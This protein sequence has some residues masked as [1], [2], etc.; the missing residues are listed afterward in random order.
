MTDNT[1]NLTDA[2]L[3]QLFVRQRDSDAFKEVF[4]RHYRLVWSACRRRLCG[5]EHLADDAVQAVFLVL[6]HHA[7]RIRDGCA[8]SAW[9]Y[10][11]AGFVSAKI[12]RAEASRREREKKAAN[13]NDIISDPVSQADWSEVRGHLDEAIDKLPGKQRDAVVMRYIAGKS[14]AQI[15]AETGV[16]HETLRKRVDAG[17]G[18][19]RSMLSAQN[20]AVSVA[21][22][23]TMIAGNSLEAAPAVLEQTLF[24]A[25]AHN[26]SAGGSAAS[27]MVNIV[28]KEIGKMMFMAKLKVA[29]GIVALAA[30]VAGTG[31]AILV[32]QSGETET[33]VA[34]PAPAA[35]APAAPSDATVVEITDKVVVKDTTRLGINMEKDTYYGGHH[36]MKKRIQENFEGTS[37]RQCQWGPVQDE[38]GTF[39]WWGMSDEWKKILIGGKYT[40]LSGPAKGATGTIKDIVNKKIRT[41]NGEQDLVYIMFDKKVPAGPPDTGVLLENLSINQGKMGPQSPTSD[42]WNSNQN[43]ISINDVPP[44]SFGCAAL[45]MKGAAAPSRYQF[46]TMD[47]KYAQTNGTWHI[48]LWA[49]AKAGDPKLRI[50]PVGCDKPPEVTPAKEW[51]KHELTVIVDKIADRAEGGTTMNI[52]FNVTGGDMLLDDVE[53]WMEGDKN[54]TAFRDDA[55]AALK[56]YNPGVIR[57]LQMGGNTVDNILAPKL[58]SYR[59]RSSNETISRGFNLPE[60]YELCEYLGAEPW[61]SLPGTMQPEEMRN[62]MEYLGGPADSKYG[63]LRTDLGHP[64]PWTETLRQIHVEFGNEAWNG[65]SD[66]R[67]GGFNGPDYWKGLIDEAKKSKYYT[68]N[69]IFHAG[70]WA[71]SPDRNARIMKDAPN[72]DCLAVAPYVIGEIDPSL[73]T[74]DKLFPWAW[75]YSIRRA[76]EPFGSMV[77]N[78]Q[79]AQKAEMELSIYEVNYHITLGNGPLEPRNRII[80]SVGGAVGL[81]N[82]LLQMMRDQKVRKQC[83][84][85]F[86]QQGYRATVGTVKLWG[87]VLNYRKDKERYRPTFLGC[88]IANKVIAGDMVETIQ[89]GV[90]PKFSATGAYQDTNRKVVTYDNVSTIWSYA[91]SKG[92]RRGLILFNLDVSQPQPVIVR[93]AGQPITT[94]RL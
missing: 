60:L 17:I 53:I 25:I 82:N 6:F 78:Y 5:R 81:L 93:F 90:N 23:G 12:A 68:K 41:S 32:A 36:L 7:G 94:T 79:N 3:L 80:A 51:K 92:N 87:I 4:H 21:G 37:Y 34:T 57:S 39:S 11:T 28:V 74:N 54:P 31:G 65:D 2:G 38:D 9:L 26:I 83:V 47:Q 16:G 75:T 86:V 46:S 71:S 52:V 85:Q 27:G 44:G 1:Q 77:K 22:L 55:V 35:I 13:M 18:K 40:I 58:R 50:S 91:F 63:K 73:D 84:F 88:E 49:K 69:V 61:Y 10:Q 14:L 20:V 45:N 15:S 56:K 19:L 62:F 89:S 29:A 30:I 72:A 76:R 67:F 42:A 24:T 66:F 59:Y 43:E 64:K 70:G 8:L 48:N 33:V